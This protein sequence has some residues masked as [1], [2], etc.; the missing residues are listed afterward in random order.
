MPLAPSDLT[1]EGLPAPSTEA[2]AHSS[3]VVAHVLRTIAEADGWISFADYMGEVLYAPG[4]GYYAAGT[5][6]FGSAGDFITAPELSPLFGAAVAA[7]VAQILDE[8]SELSGAEIIE[9]GPGTGR[10]AA[11]MLNALAER[12]RLPAR[13]RLLEVSPELRERQRA[14]LAESVPA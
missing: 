14:R 3:R 12:D 2:R 10:L 9:L 5:R 4:L 7:Q 11:D 6:K 13:Y 8:L 1:A